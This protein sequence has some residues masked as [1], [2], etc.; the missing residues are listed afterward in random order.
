MHQ[1]MDSN[2]LQILQIQAMLDPSHF[3]AVAMPCQTTNHWMQQKNWMHRVPFEFHELH[4]LQ[5]IKSYKKYQLAHTL[6]DTVN[7]VDR[8]AC[9]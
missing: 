1:K 4:F 2:T 7:T 3:S 6:D 9:L 8:F 5:I